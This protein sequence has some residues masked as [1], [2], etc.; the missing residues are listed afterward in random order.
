MAQILSDIKLTIHLMKNKIIFLFLF[1]PFLFLAQSKSN[2]TLKTISGFVSFDNK[3]LQNVN[4]FVE[5][6]TNYA[7][8]DSIGYYSIKANEKRKRDHFFTF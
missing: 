1:S 5:N 8:T 3:K 4:I 7:V 2:V 6:S